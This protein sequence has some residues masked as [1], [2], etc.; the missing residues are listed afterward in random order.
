MLKYSLLTINAI[1]Q[2]IVL[3]FLNVALFVL[4]ILAL[5]AGDFTMFV[6]LLSLAY[7]LTHTAVTGETKYNNDLADEIRR[8]KIFRTRA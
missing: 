4:A 6:V 1:I 3:I 7:I 5:L 2:T 8:Y